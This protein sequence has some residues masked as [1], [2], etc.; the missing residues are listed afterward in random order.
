MIPQVNQYVK[1]LL[2]NNVVIDGLVQKWE[3][4]HVELK[5]LDGKSL[6]ILTRP[7]DD[8]VMIKIMLEDPP[9]EKETKSN[10]EL[11]K[12]DLE[13]K[14]EEVYNQS[15]DTIDRNQNLASLKK[16]LIEQDKQI[17][18]NKLKQHHIG[19]VKKVEYGQPGFFKKSRT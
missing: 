13:T 8:I 6:M 17:V 5:S 11:Q 15:S 4:E 1:C 18:I 2:R 3:S 9:A 14:F 7:Q 12:T 10:A 16:M 19:E